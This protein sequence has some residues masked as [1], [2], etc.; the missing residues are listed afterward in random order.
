[1]HTEYAVFL[2]EWVYLHH[3]T[4]PNFTLVVSLIL[5]YYQNEFFVSG[6]QRKW[7]KE[8]EKGKKKK[9]FLFFVVL[10]ITRLSSESS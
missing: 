9:F 6:N 4:L 1:M 5:C 10:Q 2:F 3:S 7:K 8:K